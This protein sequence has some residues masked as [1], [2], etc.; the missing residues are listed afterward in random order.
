MDITNHETGEESTPS[1]KIARIAITSLVVLG[2]I[3]WS[4]SQLYTTNQQAQK[5]TIQQVNM[6][7]LTTSLQNEMVAKEQLIARI[8]V[9]EEENATLR[10]EV[11][12][13]KESLQSRQQA[14]KIIESRINTLMTENYELRNN[15]QNAP[16]ADSRNEAIASTQDMFIEKGGDAVS[17]TNMRIAELTQERTKLLGEIDQ[18]TRNQEKLTTELQVNKQK[19]SDSKVNEMRLLRLNNIIQHTRIEYQ[20]IGLR[21]TREGKTVTK[22]HSGGD[23][24]QYTVANLQLRNPDNSMVVD[25]NFVMKVVDGVTQ[26]PIPNF[27]I[28]AAFV[29]KESTGA[30]FKYVGKPIEV[31]HFNDNRKLG[32]HYDIKIFYRFDDK[33]YL[34]S[35]GTVSIV[36]DG[37]AIF[38]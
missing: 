30:G 29:S 25:E 2:L 22:V 23:H 37:K 14:I 21:K 8:N 31:V 20:S 38:L 32:K 17:N 13:L 34:L 4:A 24:W 36:K 19:L 28:N 26:E 27:E 11:A 15:P 18:L 9:L 10:T 1:S 3:A 7:S 16:K 6:Q 35:Y 33:E 12:A 5:I